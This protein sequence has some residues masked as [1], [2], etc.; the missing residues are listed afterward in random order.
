MTFINLVKAFD[1]VPREMLWNILGKE[2]YDVPA[3]LIKAIK[4]TYE[5]S[6]CRVKTHS[7]SSDWFRVITGVK[8]GR[9]LSLILFIIFMEY[10]ARLVCGKS[11]GDIFGYADSLAVICDTEDSLQRFVTV[12]DEELLAKC[13]KISR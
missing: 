5:N 4:S 1:R 10:C 3:K 12:W 11:K 6:S 7:E 8:Q 13:M 2:E 9:V